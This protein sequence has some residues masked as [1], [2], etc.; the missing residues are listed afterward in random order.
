MPA[1]FKTIP[2]EDRTRWTLDYPI[3]TSREASCRA[4]SVDGGWKCSRPTGHTGVHI[5]HHGAYTNPASYAGQYW[6]RDL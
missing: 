3:A 1:E 5:Q 2:E 4:P 6:V